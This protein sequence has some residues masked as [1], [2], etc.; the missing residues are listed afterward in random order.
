MRVRTQLTASMHFV[1]KYVPPIPATVTARLNGTNLERIFVFNVERK[2]ENEEMMMVG[3]ANSLFFA[4]Q[5]WGPMIHASN[6]QHTQPSFLHLCV[7][8]GVQDKGQSNNNGDGH[9]VV[10][11]AM[12]HNHHHRQH[13][14][15]QRGDQS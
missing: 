12:Q 11:S 9:A 7:P 4:A 10:P 6:C 14:C 13:L 3:G 15:I 2:T 8:R 5:W 1:N